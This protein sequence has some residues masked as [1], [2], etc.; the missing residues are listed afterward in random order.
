MKIQNQITV[1]DL[2]A[3][4]RYHLTNSPTY[5]RRRTSTHIRA[6]LV[7]CV[8]GFL[9]AF[10]DRSAPRAAVALGFSLV[11][12]LLSLMRKNATLGKATR[13]L[14][15]EG[16]NKELL[17]PY[18]LEVNE[19]GIINTSDFSEHRWSWQ[20]IEKVATSDEDHAYI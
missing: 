19:A 14:Y 2:V 13:D 8:P 17:G 1:D 10:V 7:L 20:A 15:S 3:F 4:N 5:K 6:A 9:V 11:F 18:T 16:E 12:I